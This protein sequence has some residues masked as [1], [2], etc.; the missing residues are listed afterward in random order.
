MG[1]LIV[2]TAEDNIINGS[3]GPLPNMCKQER[4]RPTPARRRLSRTHVR[5]KG[6]KGAKASPWLLKCLARKVVFLVSRGKN[7]ISLLL[8]PLEKL[9]EKSTFRLPT[10]E[11]IHLTPMVGLT[12]FLE[13]TFHKGGCPCQG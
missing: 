12:M 8:A 9:L 10:V 5:R 13:G 6:G 2:W 1:L 7:E 4:K 11:N 3:A